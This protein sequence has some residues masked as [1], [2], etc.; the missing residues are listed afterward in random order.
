M[1]QPPRIRRVGSAARADIKQELRMAWGG[2]GGVLKSVN[3][4]LGFER[5]GEKKARFS[6]CLTSRSLQRGGICYDSVC[7]NPL[8]IKETQLWANVS[9]DMLRMKMQLGTVLILL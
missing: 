7:K 2:S 1:E 8:Y 9:D 3:L 6:E 4:Q 5:S